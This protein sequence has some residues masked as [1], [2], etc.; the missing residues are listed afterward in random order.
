MFTEQF[1]KRIEDYQRHVQI[2]WGVVI[3][4]V[5]TVIGVS[6]YGY[7]SLNEMPGLQKIASASEA[8]LSS[9]EGRI[10]DWA[11]DRSSLTERM[12]KLESSVG[13]IGSNL[14]AARN[15]AQLYANQMGQRIRQEVSESIQRLQSRVANVESVQRE[16]GESVAELH[17]EIG[18]LH[19]E[20]AA[21]QQQNAEQV[22]E[23]RQSTQDNVN[24]IDKQVGTVN[25]QV[26]THG[27]KITALSDQVGR[28]RIT[29]ELASGKTA[30]IAPGIYVTVK[31]T[32]VAHQKV[33]GWMQ[34]AGDGRILWMHGLGAQEAFTFVTRSDNRTHELV[35]TGVQ[36]D[37]ATGYA[38]LPMATNG[39]P[40][41]VAN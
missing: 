39:A 17:T 25:N 6:W 16:T 7:S 1:D 20:M 21:M 23:L 29:F 9:V 18:K 41:L 5:V 33:D 36:Q 3:L 34:L 27:N 32:D 15:Q 31:H 28:E 12:S 37:R 11:N 2:L 10:N 14:K 8:R 22:N 35:F 30:Q 19:Q 40:A 4:L 38:L 26:I 13:S 24:R